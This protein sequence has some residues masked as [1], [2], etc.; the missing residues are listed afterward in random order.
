[1]LSCNWSR[2]CNSRNVIEIHSTLWSSKNINSRNNMCLNG[3][4][5]TRRIARNVCTQTQEIVSFHWVYLYF[6]NKLYTIQ[7]LI[8][9]SIG[10]SAYSEICAR[11]SRN[12]D[13]YCWFRLTIHLAV[14]GTHIV[15]CVNEHFI[16]RLIVFF[17]SPR[18]LPFFLSPSVRLSGHSARPSILCG[19][20][21]WMNQPKWNCWLWR[22]N[23]L[24]TWWI[25][26]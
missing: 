20:F 21:D 26:Q 14:F 9:L 4:F 12:N 22:F 24:S 2:I 11:T 16:A 5:A 15:L 1:M 23:R 8:F 6:N 25:T 3:T 18:R 19:G 10:I 13:K 17:F 7:S